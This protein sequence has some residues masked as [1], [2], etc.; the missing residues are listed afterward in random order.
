MLLYSRSHGTDARLDRSY[1]IGVEEHGGEEKE[2]K[3]CTYRGTLN[4]SHSGV[5]QDVP[6]G[7]PLLEL[8]N[9]LDLALPEQP[10]VTVI[11]QVK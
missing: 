7:R 2:N 6:L 9:G 8:A 3:T 11:V 1:L 10:K 5:R 4:L